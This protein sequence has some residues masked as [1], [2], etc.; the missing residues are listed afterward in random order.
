MNAADLPGVDALPV[1]LALQINR[2][3]DRH[4]A[5]WRAGRRPRIEDNL[6]LMDEP[7]RTV[8]LRELL[9]AELAARWEQGEAPDC[10]EYC[11]RF[12]AD[13]ALIA[14]V[15]A[16]AQATGDD[17]AT[18]GP[19]QSDAAAPSPLRRGRSRPPR[20]SRALAATCR[21]AES[22]AVLHRQMDDDRAPAAARAGIAATLPVDSDSAA[23]DALAAFPEIPE[24]GVLGVPRRGGAEIDDR[25]WLAELNR[26]LDPSRSLEAHA[27][28]PAQPPSACK[29]W[30]DIASSA[31]SGRAAWGSSTGRSTRSAACRWPSRP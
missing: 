15:F 22:P 27:D 23:A 12:P 31:S 24:S 4:E 20:R 5:A 21:G 2:L 18:P 29:G 30:A 9:A 19:V 11:D 8:L 17:P 3:S 10:R 7:G 14:A 28:D 1:L 13:A 16:E 6:T 26:E 25:A